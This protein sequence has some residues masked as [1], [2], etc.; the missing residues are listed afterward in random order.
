MCFRCLHGS[1]KGDKLDEQV[2]LGGKLAEPLDL[3]E[4]VPKT[5]LY[6]EPGMLFQVELVL[7]YK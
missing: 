4:V 1:A 7:V 3:I 5:F 6:K 2:C